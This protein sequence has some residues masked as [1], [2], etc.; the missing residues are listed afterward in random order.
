M[1][2]LSEVEGWIY[3]GGDPNDVKMIDCAV[4]QRLYVEFLVYEL[5]VEKR[6]GKKGCAGEVVILIKKWPGEL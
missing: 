1:K 6:S 3:A 5:I 2:V 4:R